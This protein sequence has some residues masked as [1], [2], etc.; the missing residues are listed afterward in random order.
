MI[1]HKR[2]DC[3][4]PENREECHIMGSDDPSIAKAHSIIRFAVKMLSWLMVIVII[5][6][7]LDVV[8][9]FYVKITTPPYFLLN[10]NDILA[11]FG[12][13]MAVLIAIEIYINITMYLKS[14]AIHVRLVL[15]TA[16]MAAARKV[17]VLDFKSLDFGYIFSLAAVLAGLG[18]CYHFVLR[19]QGR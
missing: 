16:V 15:D 6:G 4:D 11:T 13:F 14:D 12:A 17:V 3:D 8:Y 1:D 7:I 9:V 19:K 10:I 18:I 2:P 5:W